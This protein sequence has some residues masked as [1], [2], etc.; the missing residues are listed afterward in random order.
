MMSSLPRTAWPRIVVM[1]A[2]LTLVGCAS[3]QSLGP[4][5]WSTYRSHVP[6]YLHWSMRYPKTW[7]AQ[8][9]FARCGEWSGPGLIVSDDPYQFQNQA[10]SD[11]CTN[12]WAFA[13]AP[14]SLVAVDMEPNVLGPPSGPGPGH[15]PDT[16]LPMSFHPGPP[17]LQPA[18]SPGTDVK[19][20]ELP[21]WAHGL[22]LYVVRVWVGPD[23][24]QGDVKLAQDIVA[25]IRYFG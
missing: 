8:P 7:R 6:N 19:E 23:A 25:T 22:Q 24:S 15:H 10:V 13:G 14:S 5:T 18:P 12:S 2:T 20:Y 1:A 16:V 11:G 4:L 21:V 9:Y 17:V 3:A